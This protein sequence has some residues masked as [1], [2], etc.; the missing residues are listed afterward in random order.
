MKFQLWLRDEYGQGSILATDED[1]SV[2]IKKAKQV[3]TDT[4]VNNALTTEDRDNNWEMYFPIISSKKS[5]VNAEAIF[6]YGGRG[7][8]NKEIF[9]KVS[10]VDGSVKEISIDDIEEPSISIYLGNISTSRKEEKDWY[11]LDKKRK[12]INSLNSP[13]L[14]NKT[15]L[16]IKVIK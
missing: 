16:F 7:A 3:I 15:M 14:V 8:M 12:P 5:S 4:N 13:E 10:K 11:A 9:H 2:V 1:L 6:L